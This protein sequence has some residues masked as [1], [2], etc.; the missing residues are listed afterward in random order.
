ML[1]AT[2]FIVA[3]SWEESRCSSARNEYRKYGPFSQWSTTQQL[4]TMTS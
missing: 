3:R 2:L 1:I 4:K